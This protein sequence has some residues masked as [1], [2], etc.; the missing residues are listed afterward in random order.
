MP[1]KIDTGAEVTAISD[2]DSRL[3][4]MLPGRN[5]SARVLFGPT[6]HALK[7]LGQFNGT[8]QI[9]QKT[10]TETVFIVSG[11]K[12][13]L[14]G[15]PA[16]KSLQLLQQVYSVFSL[17]QTIREKFPKVFQGL[18]TLG[19]PYII[20]LKEGAKPYVLYAP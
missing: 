18:G 1:F 5:L 17:E 9:G 7:V 3:W 16:I 14:L 10:S 4:R 19:A 11:L 12:I 20:K 6:Q 13:N 2:Q 15:L 8:F